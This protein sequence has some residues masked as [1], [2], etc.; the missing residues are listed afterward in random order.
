MVAA[1]AALAFASNPVQRYDFMAGTTITLSGTST[2]HDYSCTAKVVQ[3]TLLGEVDQAKKLIGIAETK[4]TI[5]VN[6]LE[7]GKGEMNENLQKALKS[8]ENPNIVFAL[9]EVAMAGQDQKG[10]N[11]MKTKGQLAVAGVQKPIEFAA[12][13]VVRADGLIEIKR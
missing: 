10:R 8:K 6:N 3:G 13:G 12:A 4:V 11:A 2:V 9:K 1:L 5:P 7:C